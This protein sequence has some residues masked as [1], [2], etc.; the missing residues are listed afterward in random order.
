M[1]PLPAWAQEATEPTFRAAAPAAA[2]GA[3][4][5]PRLA[6]A[7]AADAWTLR[8]LVEGLEAEGPW[9]AGGDSPPL[10]RS[11]LERDRAV[12]RARRGRR[13]ALGLL[14]LS[15]AVALAVP[16]S[17]D[18]R[19]LSPGTRTRLDLRTVHHAGDGVDLVGQG[20]LTLEAGDLLPARLVLHEGRVEVV[21]EPGSPVSVELG[22][23][24]VEIASGQV[25]LRRQ[26][27]QVEIRVD[28]GEVRILGPD[29]AVELGPDDPPWSA[30]PPEQVETCGAEPPPTAGGETEATAPP[31]AEVRPRAQGQTAVRPLRLGPSPADLGL[32]GSVRLSSLEAAA[33][34]RAARQASAGGSASSAADGPRRLRLVPGAGGGP[35]AAAPQAGPA[36]PAGGVD[37]PGPRRALGP[38]PRRP[39]P[40]PLSRAAPRAAARPLPPT[41]STGWTWAQPEAAAAPQAAWGSAPCRRPRCRRC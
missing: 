26:S 15:L 35:P 30:P 24:R 17:R 3:G 22:P 33:A 19:A 37:S 23:H 4:G 41:F 10:R 5:L 1:T 28:E 34:H 9:P 36:A 27:G 6:E 29:G 16:L 8:R 32:G 31:R 40:P 2:G 13:L 21:A 18:S 14:G 20:E 7:T 25:S 38:T 11:R 39:Q 12:A